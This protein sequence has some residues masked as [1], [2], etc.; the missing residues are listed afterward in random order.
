M[1]DYNSLIFRDSL[2]IVRWVQFV[3]HFT[4][5]AKND[6]KLSTVSNSGEKLED[7]FDNLLRSNQDVRDYYRGKFEML[8]SE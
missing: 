7:L 3:L 1:S 4:H 8:K 5:S 2:E 6:F